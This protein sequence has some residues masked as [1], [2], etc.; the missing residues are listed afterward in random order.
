[1]GGC[2]SSES[3]AEEFDSPVASAFKDTERAYSKSLT[4][5][6]D[7]PT[8]SE[9]GV[10]SRVDNDVKISRRPEDRGIARAACPLPADDPAR[11][12][13][14]LWFAFEDRP[15]K[16]AEL[17][18][19]TPDETLFKALQLR[20]DDIPFTQKG[21]RRNML[22]EIMMCGTVD[23]AAR[24]LSMVR[25]DKYVVCAKDEPYERCHHPF[26][27]HIPVQAAFL[28]QS[29][30]IFD[31]VITRCPKTVLKCVTGMRSHR[32]QDKLDILLMFG[33][34]NSPKKW[35]HPLVRD[36]RHVTA[37]LNFCAYA[38]AR[39]VTTAWKEDP[40]Y[41]SGIFSEI[42]PDMWEIAGR[43][44]SN[45]SNRALAAKVR[46]LHDTYTANVERRM[47]KRQT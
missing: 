13:A 19:E 29:R 34:P 12:M 3:V 28:R 23:Q 10:V 6:N 39:I 16:R 31:L 44:N 27:C 38:I 46:E 1:M 47:K 30:E 2:H 33:V 14:I 7:P 22:R 32:C 24:A 11:D 35:W 37:D 8:A 40:E 21:L 20:T 26:S 5:D 4:E 43:C 17:L 9:R 36:V 42:T 45:R 15:H 41:G 25:P 18:E